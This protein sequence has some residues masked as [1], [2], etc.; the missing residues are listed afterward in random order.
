MAPRRLRP[1]PSA[2]AEKLG[3]MCGRRC[4]GIVWSRSHH[5]TK[6]LKGQRGWAS[7]GGGVGINIV[8]R[9]S[10]AYLH[11]KMAW[12]V[13]IV[14][15]SFCSLLLASLAFSACFLLFFLLLS[16]SSCATAAIPAVLF[17]LHPRSTS[18]WA[19]HGCCAA[20]GNSQRSLCPTLS[21]CTVHDVGVKRSLSNFSVMRRS[22]A[23]D[24]NTIDGAGV[25]TE[26]FSFGRPHFSQRD[27]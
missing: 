11:V 21:Y 2:S 9:T 7:G 6:M 23:H 18:K 14:L 26:V 3:R 5:V 22:G 24:S 19:W 13:R 25:C 27:W 15:C 17:N 4:A 8:Q 10:P 16:L 1:V 12:Y 20:R